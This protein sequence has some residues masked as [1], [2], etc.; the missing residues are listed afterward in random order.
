MSRGFRGRGRVCSWRDP[1]R[2]RRRALDP[3]KRAHIGRQVKPAL[4]RCFPVAGDGCLDH[5][6]GREARHRR[7]VGMRRSE[8]IHAASPLTTW[9]RTSIRPPLSASTVVRA[10]AGRLAGSANQSRSPACCTGRLA[11]KVYSQSPPHSR[12]NRAVSPWLVRWRGCWRRGLLRRPR[13]RSGAAR[14]GGHRAH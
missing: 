2:S 4:R 8:C 12:I 9:R 10:P 3:P 5:A 13:A 7:F 11:F 6:Q 1:R 14:M